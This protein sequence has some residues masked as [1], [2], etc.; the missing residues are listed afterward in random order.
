MDFALNEEQRMFRD[1]FRNFAAKEVAPRA[2]EMDH[3]ES[4]PKELLRKA[5]DQGFLG[6]TIPEDYAGAALDNVSYVLL[7]EN[8]ATA[9][10]SLAVTVATHVSL[11]AMSIL[12]SGTDAQ[13]EEWLPAM[14]AGEAI[15]AFALSEPDA[16]SDMLA[17]ETRAVPDGEEV[18]L[19]GVKTWVANGELAGL[20]LVFARGPQGIDAYLVPRDT[21]G[22]TVGYREP[23]LGLRSVYF[24]TVYLEGCRVPQANRLGAPGEGATIAKRAV[25]RM[26]VALAAVGLG[27]AESSVDVAAQYATERVQFGVPIGKKQAIQN[28]I[29]NAYAETEALRYLVYRAAWLMDQGEDFSV[30]ASVA[31]AFGARIARSVTNWMLQVLG[32]YGFMEDYPMARKYRDARVLGIIG[33]PTE[34]HLFNVAR[35]I[36]AQKDLVIVPQHQ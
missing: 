20:F 14:A 22:L 36:F 28:Y 2:E 17:L 16:G 18:I 12:E 11:V 10:A 23:T 6:A 31:K 24:N 30:D 29:A 21:P 1:M 34:V 5:V 4:M 32:G 7:L 25:D 9:C 35:H 15:G 27:L 3:A 8:L 13:K 26:A 33:G 19:D